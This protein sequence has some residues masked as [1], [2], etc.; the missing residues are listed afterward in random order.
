MSS[1]WAAL[2]V[3][4]R[5]LMGLASVAALAE[6]VELAART[7]PAALTAAE[8]AELAALAAP[9]EL[10]ARTAAE[11]ATHAERAGPAEL[12]ALVEPAEVEP[13]GPV[14]YTPLRAPQPP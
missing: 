13:L 7:E 3:A 10:A 6:L 8:P 11:L 4:K 5:Q 2:D 9:A 12:T 14:S 1:S